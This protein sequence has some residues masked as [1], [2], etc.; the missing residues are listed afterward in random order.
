MVRSEL[1]RLRT[2]YWGLALVVLIALAGWFM[3]RQAKEAPSPQVRAP[4]PRAPEAARRPQETPTFRAARDGELVVVSGALPSS[5]ARTAL[6]E[7]VKQALPSAVVSDD[8]KVSAT[9]LA[10]QGEAASLAVGLLGPLPSATIVIANGT[11]TV[12]GQ[13]PDADAYNAVVNAG[14]RVPPGYR[15][16]VAGLVPPLVRPYTWS[17]STSEDEIALSGYV[18]SEAARQDV[19]A[20]AARAFP[21]KRLVDRLQPGSGVPPDID[22]AAAA[23]FALSQLAHLRAGGADLVDATLSLRG[24]VTDRDSLAGIKAAVQSGL[25]PG[26]RPGSVA[27]AVRPPSPYAFRARREAGTLTLTGYYPDKA[28]RIAIDS[29]IRDRFFSEQVVNKLRTADGAPKNY[30]A[31]VSFGLDH[32]SRLASGEV[33]ISGASIEVRGEALYEQTAEQT[34]RAVRAVSLPG[35]TGKAEVRLRSS[36]KT[37][38]EP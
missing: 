35:W 8:L 23:R 12:A 1:R 5:E 19:R 31:G 11:I 6:L 27:I 20:A 3:A 9:P 38:D 22:F 13:A 10:P 32:L 28:A 34:A 24:D 14:A 25:P 17:A 15:L 7:A 30:L 37:S 18:P 29:L 36:A 4:A 33:A 16:D 21:D 2:W 26:L